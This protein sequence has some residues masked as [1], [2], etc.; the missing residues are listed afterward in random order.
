M[1]VKL[2]KKL[3]SVV[4]LVTMLMVCI[5]SAFA[6]TEDELSDGYEYGAVLVSLKPGAPSFEKLLSGL[7]IAEARLITPGSA[8]QNVYYVKFAEETKEIVWKAIEILN[9]SPFVNVAE[10]NFYRQIEP[11]ED[12]TVPCETTESTSVTETS[13]QR[14]TETA[15]PIGTTTNNQDFSDGYEHGAV[16]VSLKP[17][18]PSFEKLLSGFEITEARLI[19]PGS[20]TQNVYYVK[21]AKKTKEIVWEAIAVLNESPFVSVAEPNYYRQVEPDDGATDPY[22]TTEPISSVL[23]GDADGDGYL[24]VKDA[25]CIQ[26]Y[27]AQ[28]IPEQE[29]NCYAANISRTGTVSISDATMIQ[30]KLVGISSD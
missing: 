16:L 8:T 25:T 14:N 23:M 29:I 7:E 24:S 1:N 12:P 30:K 19:T 6:V 11:V 4:L 5:P 10:P 22:E 20:A 2:L 26:K 28:L 15:E 9:E 27:L 17:G 13:T 3:V 18:A 21:F